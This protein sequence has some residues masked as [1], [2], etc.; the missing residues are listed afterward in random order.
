MLNT[1]YYSF[2]SE[3]LFETCLA[4]TNIQHVTFDIRREMQADV[5]V[6]WPLRLSHPNEN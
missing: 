4:L 1:K 2:F 3:S 6:K 5:S